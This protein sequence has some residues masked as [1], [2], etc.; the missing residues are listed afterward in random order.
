MSTASVQRDQKAPYQQPVDEVLAAFDADARNGLSEGEARTRLERYG[1]NE[2]TAE[3]PVPRGGSSSRNSRMCS[4]SCC[5][6]QQ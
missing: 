5:S 2:L 4:L 6:S 3:K 1:R